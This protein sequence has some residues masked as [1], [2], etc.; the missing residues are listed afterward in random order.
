MKIILFAAIKEYLSSKKNDIKMYFHKAQW[1]KMNKHNKTIANTLFDV[2][3]VNVGK[4][5]YGHLNVHS[6]GNK[7]ESLVIG[8]YCSIAGNVHFILSG[9][10]DYLNFS[11]YPFYAM[12]DSKVVEATTK[13][14]IRIE[15]DV[16]IGYGS[17]VLSGVKI[18]R[19]A[20][21]AAGSIVTRD[22]PPYAIWINNKVYK[23]RFS[24]E[25]IDKLMKIDYSSI[26]SKNIATNN[27]NVHID[28]TNIDEIL[29]KISDKQ[30]IGQ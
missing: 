3:L 18:G 20:V 17:I 27:L 19:G 21:I 16:W 8:N 11:T 28:E 4:G 14:E 13:G 12:N 9:G 25:I 30:S 10:H 7:D 15:D 26:D 29:I 1:K 5:S 24:Q 6:Y 2:S 22:V 23:Y